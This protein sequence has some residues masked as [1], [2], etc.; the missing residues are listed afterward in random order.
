[1]HLHQ[2]P[3]TQ[4]PPR[5]TILRRGV[6]WVLLLSGFLWFF[7]D[8]AA[9]ESRAAKAS[10]P[11]DIAAPSGDD[12]ASLLLRNGRFYTV[13]TPAIVD[14]SMVVQNGRIAFLGA[15][16]EALRWAGPQTQI[17]EL[18][19]R[20][21]TPGW[22]DAHSHLLNLGAALE[23]ADLHG[24]ST[25]E[26]V[27][28]RL[29]S[30]AAGLPAGSWVEGRGWDQNDWPKTDFPHHQALSEA[31]PNHPVWATRVDGHAVL[32]NARAMAEL[33][34]DDSVVNPSGGLYLRDD[35]EGLSGV[36]IDNAIDAVASRRP[37]AEPQDLSRQLVAAAHHCLERGLT[38]V[39]DMGLHQ[40]GLDAYQQLDETNQLPIR[41]SVYLTDH[42]PLLERWMSQGTR[43]DEDL[44]FMVRGIKLY[45]DGALGSRGAALVEPYSDDEGNL[46]LLTSS[47]AHMEDVARRA[48][49]AGFQVGVHAIGDRGGLVVLD[50]LERAFGGKPQPQARFRMEH[51]QVMRL[52]DIQRLAQLGIIA[53]MQPTHATSDMPWAGARVGDHRLEGAYAWRK[54]LDAGGRLALGSDFPVERAAP[55]LGFYAAVTRQDLEGEPADGWL[56]Q[57]RLSRAEALRGFTLDAAYSL[58][59][60]EELGSLDVGKRA[61]L[62]IFAQDPM[63]VAT[64]ELPTIAIDWTLVEGEIA[65]A[66]GESPE[67]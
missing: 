20:A 54:V 60:E 48:L 49:D 15:T 57:E 33:E 45:A 19:G 41:S 6:F 24:A 8:P 13:S 2:P 40:A 50:A 16:E 58:F 46:G 32:L 3:T 18:E 39:T 7:S 61:D 38:T 62:V 66:R 52:A 22:I 26:E 44:R 31:L 1:M 67:S 14:G 65:F 21:V 34:L 42:A 4:A 25:Y 64:Q 63:S 17:L 47:G 23:Q 12:H 29:Q 59:L 10:S 51:A 43:W 9:T 28:A 35:Q 30:A 36:L 11:E 53:S 27:I 55:L 56:P 37:A 5:S